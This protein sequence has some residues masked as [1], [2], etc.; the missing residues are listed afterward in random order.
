MKM[1]TRLLDACAVLLGPQVK[2]RDPAYLDHLDVAVVRRAYRVL[3]VA[4]HP[5]AA[6]RAGSRQGSA[7]GKRFI[8]ASHAYELLMKY[9]LN[10]TSSS[11]SP[12]AARPRPAS[13]RGSASEKRTG[14][15]KRATGEKRGGERRGAG[16]A[17]AGQTRRPGSEKRSSSE[18]RSAGEKKATGEKKST[19]G[20]KAAGA[21]GA[22]PRAT[23]LFFHGQ[24]PRRRLRLAEFLYYSGR[25]S[26]Q[27]LINA[28]VWQR[29]VKP[30]FGELARELREISSQDL[31]KILVS[32]L[33][34]EQTGETALRLRLLTARE[35]QRILILQ[36]ARHRPIGRYFVEKG[37][38]SADELNLIIREMHRHNVLYGRQ[39]A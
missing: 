21:A 37:G 15:D 8:E 10:R 23:E 13:S 25:V 28:I 39:Q 20:K 31:A 29:M 3:A 14:Q 36:R 4:S 2:V 18:K 34:G 16:E 17:R 27:S 26:W 7:D 19:G 33:R 22:S 5:D 9:L 11:P 6:R 1:E 32:K 12:R 30:K 38:L 24:V 35:V